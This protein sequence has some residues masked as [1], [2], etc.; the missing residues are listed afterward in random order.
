MNDAGLSLESLKASYRE[1]LGAPACQVA[2]RHEGDPGG[3]LS[4]MNVLF[5]EQVL[6]DD[7]VPKRHTLLATAGMS[8]SGPRIE[9]LLGVTGGYSEEDRRELASALAELAALPARGELEFTVPLILR[10]IR[11][12]LF[13]PMSCALVEDAGPFE[14]RWLPASL[15]PVLLLTVHPLYREEAEYLERCP[16]ESAY[17]DFLEQSVDWEDPRRPPAPIPS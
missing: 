15:E 6:E 17:R 1:W 9:L 11:W 8:L 4:A 10:A 12:P 7:G 5:F 16:S 13:H 2:F 3:D 14:E